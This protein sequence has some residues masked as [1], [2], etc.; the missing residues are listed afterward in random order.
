MSIHRVKKNSE[1]ADVGVMIEK[2]FSL[3][4][5]FQDRDIHWTTYDLVTEKYVPFP[6]HS[7]NI[8]FRH[9]M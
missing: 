3:C 8:L 6:V 5:F 4:L 7:L 2:P 9:G 1:K